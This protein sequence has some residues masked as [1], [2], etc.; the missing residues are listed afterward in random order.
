MKMP[1][2]AT[3]SRLAAWLKIALLAAVMTISGSVRFAIAEDQAAPVGEHGTAAAEHGEGRGGAH[4]IDAKT[5]ALQFLNFGVLLFLL[6]KFGGK[7][8]NKALQTRHDHLKTSLDEAAR[9]RSTAAARLAEQEKR[10]Q[11][12]SEEIEGIRADLKRNAES[13]RA[14]LIAAAEEKAKRIQDETS[15]LLSQQVKQAELRFRTEVAEAAVKIAEEVLR[16]SVDAM[17]DQ[18]LARTFIAG[19]T[20]PPAS[21]G[22]AARTDG[23]RVSTPPPEG[24]AN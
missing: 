22:S 23:E 17:D 8:V 2:N 12:L 16:R 21:E 9:L 5:L 20:T 7:A 4:P 10:L 19:V 1:A 13:E 11:N 14:R 15:F 18:R 6:I 24:M 3:T